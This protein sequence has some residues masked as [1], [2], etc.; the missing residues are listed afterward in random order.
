VATPPRGLVGIGLLFWPLAGLALLLMLLGA[1]VLLVRPRWA[2][3]LFM[4]MSLCQAG[5][6]GFI[7]MQSVPGLGLPAG[8]FGHEMLLRMAFDGI[9][10]AAAVH[11]F[12]VHPRR[13]P[14]ATVVAGTAWA[15]VLLVLAAAQGGALAPLWWWAQGLAI[16][17]SAAAL[18]V[19]AVSYRIEPNP[20]TALMRRF[21]AVAAATLVLASVAAGVA[22]GQPG[23]SPLVVVAGT[24]VWY[25]FLA[26]LLLPALQ[27]A[28]HC[29]GLR[30]PMMP[31][32]PGP[33]A[34][35]ADYNASLALARTLGL[36]LYGSPMEDAWTT[37]GGICAWR[38]APWPPPWRTA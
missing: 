37:R 4:L 17:L 14:R 3:G 8:L 32:L 25:L 31:Q 36:A 29:T 5:N 28:M 9:S 2:N 21:S 7:A 19:L 22:A 24:V 35:S 1:A 15:L 13:L 12:A 6:L 30:V 38:A 26:S 20:L 16:S 18:V 34:Y 33:G 11:A 27:K 10:G 23:V